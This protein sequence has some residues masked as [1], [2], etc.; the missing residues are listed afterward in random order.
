MS[1]SPNRSVNVLL[2]RRAADGRATYDIIHGPT[3]GVTPPGQVG[4]RRTLRRHAVGRERPQPRR[5]IRQSATPGLT[6]IAGDRAAV[7]APPD[8]CV[9]Y[10]TCCL[11]SALLGNRTMSRRLLEAVRALAPG[12]VAE[13]WFD[14]GSYRRHP[15]PAWA[16]RSAE[17]EA[18]LVAARALSGGALPDAELYVV[19]TVQLAQVA[20][21]MRPDARFVVATDATPALTDRLRARAYGAPRS[22]ARRAFRHVQGTRFGAFARH[23]DA[24]L[25]MSGACRDSLVADYGVPAAR[26]LVTSA[27]QP[28]VDDAP[29]SARPERDR[30]LLFVGN[31][32]LRKGG[33]ELCA[34]LD[35]LP[36][37]TLTVVSRDPEARACVRRDPRVELVADAAG[38]ESLVPRYRTADL[39]VHPTYVDHWSHVICEGLARGL[40]FAVTA[41][42]PPA[43][44][45][46]ASGAGETI[47]WPPTAESI[48]AAVRG[49][50]ADRE[51]HAARRTQALAYARR[52]LHADVFR[53][54]L[55]TVLTWSAAEPRLSTATP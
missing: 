3:I 31:D 19:N 48:A 33:R 51:R 41:G 42:T 7:A 40:P 11:L 25:P 37:A 2:R 18:E 29:P 1:A 16:R 8:H 34:A 12:P 6:R 23:V 50:L 47:A 22:L 53:R 32:F 9:S 26:C 54:R 15:A 21:R 10:R 35:L 46:A 13:L 27:P 38:P 39:L 43:E 30:R 20:A 24:W 17:L 45:V 14:D 44:L 4:N 28:D 52:E 36:G 49:A 5:R 55:A